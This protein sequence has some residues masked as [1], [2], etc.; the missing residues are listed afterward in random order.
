MTAVHEDDIIRDLSCETHFMGHYNYGHPLGG[1][2]FNDF[3]DFAGKSV[4]RRGGL[5][6]K[7][8]PG[9]LR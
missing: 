2:V 8:N 7:Q 9:V 3:K 5:V 6:E 1:K 4:E